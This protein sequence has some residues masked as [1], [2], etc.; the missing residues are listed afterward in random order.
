MNYLALSIISVADLSL[1]VIYCHRIKRNQSRLLKVFLEYDHFTELTMKH[2]FRIAL[3]TLAI[4]GLLPGQSVLAEP[5]NV[6]TPGNPKPANEQPKKCDRWEEHEKHLE[7]LK[8]DLK[9]NAN[10]EAA[11]AEWVGKMKENRQDWQEKRKNAE[12]WAS[13]PALDRMEKMLAFSKEHIARQEARLAAT[14]IFYATLS[15]EQRLTFDKGFKFEHHGHAG[16]D[17]KK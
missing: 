17:W 9:L 13:L 7:T 1:F 6:A 3:F 11:W 2:T 10:Q 16:K 4:S 8:S 15:P 14:K 5:T 12:V